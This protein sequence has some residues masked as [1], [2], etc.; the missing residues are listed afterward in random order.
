MVE[1]SRERRDRQRL[2]Q[3]AADE[4]L[5]CRLGISKNENGEYGDWEK[6]MRDPRRIPAKRYESDS[7]NTRIAPKAANTT[8]DDDSEWA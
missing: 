1:K 2:A 7:N 6:W 4:E 5:D 3:E 8:D